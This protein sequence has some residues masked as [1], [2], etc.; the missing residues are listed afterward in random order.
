MS[1]RGKLSGTHTTLIP[2]ADIVYQH[3]RRFEHVTKVG[4]GRIR[5]GLHSVPTR[6]KVKDESGC[7][8]LVIRAQTA[9]QDLRIYTTD[10]D[11]AKLNIARFVRKN[12]WRLAFTE[13][14]NE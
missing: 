2:V 3:L 4:A 14:N 7:I 9:C 13:K 6:V 12:D 8:L 10:R 1:R 5:A 11:E